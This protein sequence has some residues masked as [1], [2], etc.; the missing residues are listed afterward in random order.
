MR[1]IVAR[2]APVEHHGDFYDMPLAGGM[3]LGKALKST[4][5]PL[6]TTI[7]IH[8][9]AEGPKNVA[10]AAEI[11][12]GWLPLFFAPKE[13]GVLPGLPAPRASRPPATRARPSASR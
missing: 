8:L 7:P 3:G 1:R 13:D 2:D 4:V 12:D 11:G 9:A 10:L 5:H 6:R